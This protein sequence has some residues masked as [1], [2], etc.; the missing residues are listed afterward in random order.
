MAQFIVIISYVEYELK[1]MCG[2][3]GFT[4]IY[5]ENSFCHDLWIF[6]MLKKFHCKTFLQATGVISVS[7]WSNSSCMTFI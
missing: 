7:L 2:S 4:S 6:Y 3:L 1:Y 5:K